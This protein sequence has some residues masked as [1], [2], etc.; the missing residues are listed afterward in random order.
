[1]VKIVPMN[2]AQATLV[3]VLARI[4]VTTGNGDRVSSTVKTWKH[5]HLVKPVQPQEVLLQRKG[6]PQRW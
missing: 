6:K 2:V 1:M 3:L 5:L 4:C